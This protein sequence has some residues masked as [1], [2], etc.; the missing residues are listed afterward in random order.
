MFI[1]I[2]TENEGV[3]YWTVQR[4]DGKAFHGSVCGYNFILENWQLAIDCCK[5]MRAKY[6]ES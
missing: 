6:G 4:Q 3:Q 5:A 1:I 2:K